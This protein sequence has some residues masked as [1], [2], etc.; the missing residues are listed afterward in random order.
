MPFCPCN[1]FDY[2][3]SDG[4]AIGG[5]ATVTSSIVEGGINLGGSALVDVTNVSYDGLIAVWPLDELGNGTPDEYQDRGSFGLHGTAGEIAPA[6]ASGVFCLNCN[7]FSETEDLNGSYISL[8]ADNLSVNHKFSVSCWVKIEDIYKPRMIFSRGYQDDSGNEW[9]F[10]LGYS[11]LN[12]L[13]ASVQMNSGIV[14]E[15][16]STTMMEQGRFYH[17]ATCFEPASHLKVFIDGI[18]EATE[19]VTESETEAVANGSYFGRFNLGGYPTC[20]LQEVRLYP[21][22]QTEDYWAA[23]HDNFCSPLFYSIGTEENPS[24]S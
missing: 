5:S 4:L 24:Y 23:E 22:C 17:V 18:E 3:M 7:Y 16:Y 13:V 10:Y 15:A 19:S 9:A 8:P 12:H 14:Y 11:Y 1:E 21:D 6:L 2:L 20:Y